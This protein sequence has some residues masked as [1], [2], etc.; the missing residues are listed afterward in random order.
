MPPHVNESSA[1]AAALL[2]KAAEMGDAE[3]V[4]LK[5]GG[6]RR[7]IDRPIYTATQR[8]SLACYVTPGGGQPRQPAARV[9]S[10]HW[11]LMRVAEEEP[12]P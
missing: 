5:G 7:W 3:E 6:W 1:S 4:R 2:L 11:V 9:S 10:R 12:L 8:N